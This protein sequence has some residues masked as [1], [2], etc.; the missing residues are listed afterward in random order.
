MRDQTENIGDCQLHFLQDGGKG[1]ADLLFLHGMKFQAA[2]WSELGTLA[3]MA[4]EGYRATALDLPGFGLSPA[5][6]ADPLEVVRNFIDSQ[7]LEKTILVGPS[8]GGRVALEFAL[9]NPGL[10]AGLVLVGA[11]GVE[12]NRQRLAEIKVPTLIIWGGEDAISPVSNGH[13]LDKEIENSQLLIIDSAPHPCYL[14][15]PDIFHWELTNFL[16]ENFG[17]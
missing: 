5:A 13:L 9:A 4:A 2:T 16:A 8:M 17:I 15:E 14:E 3:K 6:E 11:V 10:L 1:K 12:E 7:G